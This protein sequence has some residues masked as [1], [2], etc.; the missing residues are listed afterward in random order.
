MTMTGFSRVWRK[1]FR[2]RR[3]FLRRRRVRAKVF[4]SSCANFPIECGRTNSW[5]FGSFAH[6]SI[7]EPQARS[8]AHHSSA[9]AWLSPTGET[10]SGMTLFSFSPSLLLS[11]SPSLLLSFSPTLLR[12]AISR[13]FRDYIRD[14]DHAV[15]PIVSLAPRAAP[16]P[17]ARDKRFPLVLALIP[18]TSVLFLPLG[19]SRERELK[20]HRDSSRRVP[21]LRDKQ[22]ARP[23]VS[24]RRVRSNEREAQRRENNHLCSFENAWSRP[25]PFAIAFKHEVLPFA[26]HSD[27]RSNV[28]VSP[29]QRQIP[30]SEKSIVALFLSLS[31]FIQ[32]YPCFSRT[33]RNRASRAPAITTFDIALQF[34]TSFFR[35]RNLPL[36]SPRPTCRD[37]CRSRFPIAKESHL[38]SHPPLLVAQIRLSKGERGEPRLFARLMADVCSR[39]A[40]CATGNSVPPRS[41]SARHEREAGKIAYRGL[42]I[43]EKTERGDAGQTRQ[44]ETSETR[45]MRCCLSLSLSFFFFFF[46]FY[47]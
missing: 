23:F 38:F 4:Q 15:P 9:P 36:P 32:R 1:H 29:L 26:R 41:V 14:Y 13:R 47:L 45:K 37:R 30:L 12:E 27:V 18:F 7:E 19:F 44:R 2:K 33:K 3:F 34:A 42:T 8:K 17:S 10:D 43:R 22:R 28:I 46:F 16:S 31:L 25:P 20:S 40:S 21:S 24:R 39:A 35:P 11:F 5:T 6:R